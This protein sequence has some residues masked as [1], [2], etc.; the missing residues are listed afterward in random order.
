MN[1]WLYGEIKPTNANLINYQVIEPDPG[2]PANAW[3]LRIQSSG[4]DPISVVTQAVCAKLVDV[5]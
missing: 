4:P 2:Q 3:E 1:S 5:P